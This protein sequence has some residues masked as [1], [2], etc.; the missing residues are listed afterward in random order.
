MTVRAYLAVPPGGLE[1]QMSDESK[2]PE[3]LLTMDGMLESEGRPFGEFRI[4]YRLPVPEQGVPVSLV[5]EQQ[6]RPGESFV[7]RLRIK[8]EGS[9]REAYLAT[10]AFCDSQVGRLLDALEKSPQR[11]N[12]RAPSMITMTASL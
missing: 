1:P 6:L 8:D 12:T 11:D 3:V 4:R 5:S 7:M 2:K 9:G 10:I